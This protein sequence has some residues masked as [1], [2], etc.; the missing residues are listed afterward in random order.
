VWCWGKGEQGQLGNG[1]SASS[2]VPVQ[3]IGVSDAV[4][5]TVGDRHSCAAQGDGSVRCWGDNASGQLGDGSVSARPTPVV[6]AA[7]GEAVMV[8]AALGIDGSAF[9]CART[10]G[11]RVWCWGANDV[12]QLGGGSSSAIAP[13]AVEVPS[14]AEVSTLSL[15]A[16]HACAVAG[17]AVRCWG[18]L[19]DPPGPLADVAIEA[20]A[21]G[22]LHSCALGADKRVRCWGN[23]DNGQLGGAVDP[24]KGFS[25]V[26]GVVSAT[27]IAAGALHSCAAVSDGTLFCWGE[28]NNGRLGDGTA[29]GIRGRPVA[30]TFEEL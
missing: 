30:V 23:N 11:G 17:G 6:V 28:N 21:T 19:G 4:S 1:A 27:A 15:G 9:S 10:R 2:K 22:A 16:V 13:V 8:A 20:V 3:A 12:G 5:L 18:A 7:I 14:L 29:G 26:E 24:E 25:V